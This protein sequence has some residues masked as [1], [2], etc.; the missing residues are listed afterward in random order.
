[1]ITSEL[2][3]S[4]LPTPRLS[5]VADDAESTQIERPNRAS[6]PSTSVMSPSTSDTYPLE[7]SL[8]ALRQAGVPDDLQVCCIRVAT[9]IVALLVSRSTSLLRASVATSRIPRLE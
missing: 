2:K 3:S 1:M 8:A 9:A 4:E 6:L 7:E 5:A